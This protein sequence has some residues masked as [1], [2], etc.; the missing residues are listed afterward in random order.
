MHTRVHN[1]W[2]WQE[3]F[4]FAHAVETQGQR[5]LF[6]AGQVS[7]DEQGVPCHRGDMA[8]QI[9]QVFDNLE[10]VLVKA[11]ASLASVV[12]LVYYT[13]DTDQLLANW[14][15]VTERLAKGG[16]LPASSLLGIHRLSSPDF[17]LEIEATAVL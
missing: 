15:I 12:R 5:L 1:P 6:L 16:C 8:A 13:T 2:R 9:T 11:Q 3:K 10:T 4:G 17:L 7:V 14:P